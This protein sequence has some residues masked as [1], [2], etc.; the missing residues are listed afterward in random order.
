MIA[1]MSARETLVALLAE[2]SGIHYNWAV[3]M[4]GVLMV[5]YVV[6][7]GCWP[8][9]GPDHQSGS[10]DGG[11]IMLSILVMAHFSFS[12]ST[13]FNAIAHARMATTWSI[14]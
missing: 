4:V 8:P 5:S 12:F 13:F 1:Q 10:A 9:H 6:F 11:T 7:G 14:F 2:G 3:V